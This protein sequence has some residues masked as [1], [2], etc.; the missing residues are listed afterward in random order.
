[1]SKIT[2]VVIPVAGLG[3]RFLPATKAIPKEMIT[4]VDKPL[5]QYVV[6]EAAKAGIKDVILVTHS[7]KGSI[8]NHFDQNIELEANLEAKG[9]NK[10]LEI[11]QTTCP[12][13]VNI[14][15]VRQPQAHGLG[16]AVYC[17]SP[18]IGQN[19]FAVILPDVLLHNDNTPDLKSMIERFENTGHSQIM[20][21]PVPMS[22]V[23][24]YGVA[25][26]RGEELSKGES[27]PMI[28]MVEKPAPEQAPSNLSVTGRY[29]L[30]NRCMQ[31]LETTEKCHTGEVQLTTAIDALMKEETVEAYHLAGQSYDCGNKQGYLQAT[32]EFGLRHPDLKDT[33]TEYLKNHV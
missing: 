20:V 23:S 9:K 29:I 21:E 33:F 27:K 31:I 3:T 5:I 32:V 13:G 28:A 25:D 14:I 12:N 22:E 1:M 26:I 10:L 18:V 6:E 17:A 30:S 16:H 11:A 24:S 19:D 2:Q 4:L 7:S 8:E 15:A